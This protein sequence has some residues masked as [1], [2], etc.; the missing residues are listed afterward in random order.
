MT[1]MMQRI[2]LLEKTVK[3]QTEE[4]R[5]KEKLISALEKKRLRTQTGP[6]HTHSNSGAYLERRCQE[7]QTQVQQM[8]EF[9]S[10]YGLVWVGDETIDG[11]TESDQTHSS[12]QSLWDGGTSPARSFSMN[13]DLVLQRIQDLNILTGEGQCFIQT[14]ASGA[15]LAKKDPVPLKLYGNGI[16]MF[17]GPFRSFQ[18]QSTQRCMQDLM[19]GYFPSELQQRFPD[20]VPFEVQDRRHETFLVRLPWDTFPG[21]GRAVY[22]EKDEESTKVVSLQSPEKKLTTDQF[23]R[24]LPK[25]VV[26]AGRVINIRNSLRETLQVSSDSQSSSSE[27]LVDTPAL[28]TAT[29]REQKL[30]C[31][32]TPPKPVITLKVKSEDG[33]QT[34]MV[35]MWLSET[36]GHLRSYLDQHRG[37]NESGYD[38]ISTHPRSIYSDDDMMIQSCGFSAN[39]TVL[40]QKRKLTSQ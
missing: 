21:E 2:T 10:D 13:F 29:S 7:L 25:M 40:L 39:S 24:K 20:G 12:D 19:D 8:E 11:S 9:L 16:M 31:K 15:K 36:V 4:I 5:N 37:S 30:N 34:Y 28:Q 17:D 6:E 33:D 18:E 35:K 26:K 38:I 3:S 23:L 1:A 22:E 14:T 32:R 27:I